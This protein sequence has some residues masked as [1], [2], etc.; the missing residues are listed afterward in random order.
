MKEYTSGLTALGVK[1]P[2]LILVVNLLIILGGFASILGVDVR[3]L[4]NVDLPVVTVRAFYDGASPKTI[5]TEVTSIIEGA[6]ALVSGVKNIRASSEENNA[7]LRIEFNSSVDID[8]AA[9]DVREAVNRIQRDLP[10]DIEQVTVVKADD[11]AN[12]VI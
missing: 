1:R 7:R 9:S 3:E 4:P 10:E 5:D 2:V 6:V 11:D 12:A 8:A